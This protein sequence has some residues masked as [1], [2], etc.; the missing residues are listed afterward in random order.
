[1][2]RH[3][4]NNLSLALLYESLIFF[5]QFN[6]A[7]HPILNKYYGII[8]GCFVVVTVVVA[9]VVLNVAAAVVVASDGDFVFTYINAMTSDPIRMRK[10]NS[11][12]ISLAPFPSIVQPDGVA[13]DPPVHA[14]PAGDGVPV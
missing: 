2:F 6:R 1:M 9:N 10:L 11:C 5:S 14:T 4:D 13:Q 8:K 12:L 3:F 7:H